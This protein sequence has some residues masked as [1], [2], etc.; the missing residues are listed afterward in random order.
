[1]PRQLLEY[2]VTGIYTVR[3]SVEIHLKIV[4]NVMT[5]ECYTLKYVPDQETCFNCNSSAEMQTKFIV[6]YVQSSKVMQVCKA[7]LQLQWCKSQ[8]LPVFLT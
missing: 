3:N 4:A 7:I 2:L 8:F 5:K 1:M 6:S